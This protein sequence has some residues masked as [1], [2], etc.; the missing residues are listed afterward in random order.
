MNIFKKIAMYLTI[1]IVATSSAT[2][3]AIPE[4]MAKE[5]LEDYECMAL[6]IYFE[7]RGQ[8]LADSAAVADVVL[9]R[10]LDMRYPS[11]VCGVVK[12]AVLNSNGQP[13]RNKCQFSWFCDGKSDTPHDK[14]SWE[15][16]KIIAAQVMFDGRFR[17]ITE[18]STHYHAT[19]VNPRW[20]SSLVLIGRIGSHIYYRWD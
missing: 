7:T 19:Y 11:T 15:R 20:A 17:G 12:D 8:N 1:L 14:R 5:V 6:N 18:G 16:S 13:V 4:S 9:N 2:T 3:A 10:K